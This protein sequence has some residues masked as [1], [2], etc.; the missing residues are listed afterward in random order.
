MDFVFS[1][2]RPYIESSKLENGSKQKS[3]LASIKDW[4]CFHL[5]SRVQDLHYVWIIFFKIKHLLFQFF[6]KMLFTLILWIQWN[7]HFV[8]LKLLK[9]LNSINDFYFFET[10]PELRQ[11]SL[12]PLNVFLTFSEKPPQIAIPIDDTRSLSL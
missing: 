2:E 8:F 5:V 9:L 12:A 10:I 7:G 11:I 3:S 6:S 1:T 4:E